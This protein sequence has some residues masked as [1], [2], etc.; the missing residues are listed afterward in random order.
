MSHSLDLDGPVAFNNPFALASFLGKGCL[1][2][3][4]AGRYFPQTAYIRAGKVTGNWEKQ[5]L[6]NSTFVMNTAGA[7][8][9]SEAFTP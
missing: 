8:R 4:A 2:I 7:I 5:I 1:T 3:T 9:Q 6:L